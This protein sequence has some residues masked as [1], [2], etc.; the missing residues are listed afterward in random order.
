[1]VK[2]MSE[3]VLECD[4][5]IERKQSAPMQRRIS[6]IQITSGETIQNLLPHLSLRPQMVQNIVTPRV[7][8][9]AALAEAA[10]RAAGEEC[11]WRLISAT[12]MPTIGETCDLVLSAI[13]D[14]KA[15][16]LQPVVNITGGTKLM[17]L[18]AWEAARQAGIPTVYTDT[19]TESF[20]DGG[21]A[22]GLNDLFDG[23]L[24]FD[25]VKRQM[26]VKILLAAHGIAL[27][28]GGLDP[29]RYLAFANYL[30]ADTNN[31][32]RP[33]EEQAV[34]DAIHGERSGICR[35]GGEPK[36]AD[37]WLRLLDTPIQMPDAPAR[38]AIE[39]G[40]LR[41]TRGRLFLPEAGRDSFQR[42]AAVGQPPRGEHAQQFY[43]QLFAAVRPL[44]FAMAMLTGGWVEIVA[45]HAAKQSGRFRDLRW[46]IETGGDGPMGWAEDDIVGVDGVR[47]AYFSCKRGGSK[48]KMGR[49]LE[50]LE[51]S[52]RRLGGGFSRK[53]MCIGLPP[54]RQQFD[55]LRARGKELGTR[56]VVGRDLHLPQS[57]VPS[58]Q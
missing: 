55:V 33:G 44:Q 18:G 34:R 54:T 28:S 3:D 38:L 35:N 4:K 9:R 19:E 45:Y 11:E 16:G 24:S 48:G 20:L 32:N 1:M 53:F 23:D 37:G 7:S 26:D 5:S 49:A 8:A 51:S 14:G 10:A 46:S 6:L 56:L 13:A 25:P 36:S 17:S 47:L 29:T 15:K 43:K 41:D 50:E 58:N 42:L 27:R 40:L 39:A 31:P 12:A 2:W 21:T 22:S 57:Y 30:H 52:A